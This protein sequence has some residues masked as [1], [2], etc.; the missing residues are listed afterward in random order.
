MGFFDGIKNFFSNLFGSGNKVNNT[1]NT[2]KNTATN[3]ANTVSQVGKGKKETQ[4]FTFETLPKNLD[5]LLKLPEAKLDTPF[6]TTALVMVALL[7]YKENEEEM[8]K[9]LDHL[10]G[11]DAINPYT[12]T[13]IHDR[14][15]GRE[16]VVSSFFK[17]AT[18]DNDYTPTQPYTIEVS[19]NPYSFDN[20]NYA[21]LWLQSAGADSP[22]AMALRKKPSTG[23]WFFR[24]I[25]CIGDI[26]VPKSENPW[27]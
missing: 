21:T 10:N 13:F 27:A 12:R 14:L 20:E 11:P 6:K 7:Q 1:V 2:V 16:Y 9:M 18:V 8:F 24:E 3:V 25:Q 19:S 23:E 4:T 22:R 5:E 26:R 15:K 17:G